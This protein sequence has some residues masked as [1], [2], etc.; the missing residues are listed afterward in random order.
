MEVFL[1][2]QN[3]RIIRIYYLTQVSNKSLAAVGSYGGLYI[4]TDKTLEATTFFSG[5][6]D[7]VRI[8][9]VAL[10]AEEI[11]ALAQ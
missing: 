3:Q 10:T 4:G 8:Y 1:C 9:N 2:G 5:L 11:E 6:I 7:D